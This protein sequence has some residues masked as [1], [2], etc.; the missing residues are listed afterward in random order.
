MS[1]VRRVPYACAVVLGVPLALAAHVAEPAV[2]VVPGA[3][4]LT[5]VL[6]QVPL[7]PR[8]ERPL[9]PRQRSELDRHLERRARRI[10]GG[11]AD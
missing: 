8:R 5:L 2:P 9:Y 3:A 4:L 6:A 1:C 11:E 10:R 7:P